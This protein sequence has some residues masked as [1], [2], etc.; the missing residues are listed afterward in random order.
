MDYLEKITAF[1]KLLHANPEASEKEVVTRKLIKEFLEEN[2]QNLEIVDKGRWLYGFHNEGADETY[3]FRADFDAILSE[4][5]QCYHGCG[6]DGH[7]A[8]LAGL[9]IKLDKEKLG[10]NIVYLFQH[11]EENAAGAI[12]CTEIF[13]EK[14]IDY[15]FALHGHVG[16]PLGTAGIHEE[17]VCC[18]SEGM[19]IHLKGVQSHASTPEKGINPAYLMAE[20]A[21]FLRPLC[22]FDGFV[23]MT[24]QGENYNNMIMATI[25]YQRLGELAF[26]VSP[27]TADMG[28]TLRA[29]NEKEMTLLQEKVE[30]F[31]KE[32]A[33][34][35]G[36]EF[37]FTYLDI[38][39]E[40]RNNRD[41]V[42]RVKALWEKENL[43]FIEKHYPHRGSE[44]FGHL[45]K[46]VPSCY[47]E[48]GLGIDSPP[49]HNVGFEFKDEVI[50]DGLAFFEVIARKGV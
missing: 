2:T 43:P 8:I 27:S 46:Y 25:V 45:A 4:D 42:G 48:L 18:A 14:K 28:L 3:L 44:D 1:R 12:E 39:P 38:F 9:A 15:A 34:K 40:T 16:M 11:A 49:L 7:T 30:N 32:G 23:P 35:Q 50:A 17:V 19:L 22:D 20:L 24:W 13:K 47:F 26:G 21:L 36:L 41:L 6:H 5:G 29:Y 10:R 37:S 33:E 31:I